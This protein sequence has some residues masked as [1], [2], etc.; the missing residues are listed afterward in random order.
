MGVDLSHPM[1]VRVASQQHERYTS[2][3]LKSVHGKAMRKLIVRFLVSV[4]ITEN[5]I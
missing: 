2:R 5:N 3:Y 4:I 1:Y